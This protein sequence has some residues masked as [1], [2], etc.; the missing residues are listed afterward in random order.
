M[1]ASLLPTF[2]QSETFYSI[3]HPH[4]PSWYLTDL[5]CPFLVPISIQSN[6]SALALVFAYFTN[7]PIIAC[8]SSSTFYNVRAFS[9]HVPQL[10]GSEKEKA[11]CSFSAF[12]RL[13]ECPEGRG[14]MGYRSSRRSH[15]RLMQHVVGPVITQLLRSWDKLTREN[16]IQCL[17][18]REGK[19]IVFV[20]IHK[21]L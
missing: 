16:V 21:L 2:Y 1:C 4:A 9:A 10:A 6:H 11:S 12:Q 3:Q 19:S 18:F 17:K 13:V 20:H 15:V 5:Y 7:T 14:R 8:H